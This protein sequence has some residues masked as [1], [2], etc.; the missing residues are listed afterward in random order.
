MGDNFQSLQHFLPE[1]VLIFTILFVIITDLVPSLKVYS[2]NFTLFGAV[3]VGIMMIIMGPGNKLIFE[4]MLMD[5]VFS[6]YFKIIIL[7]STISVILVSKYSNELDDEY[8]VE[9]NVLLLIALLGMF[10]MTS[11]VNLIMIYLSLE[12]VSIPS[13]ILAGILKNDKKSNEASLKYV[14]FGSFASGLMLFGFS[15]L[16]GI[17]GSTNIYD[18]YKSILVL[19]DSSILLISILFILV[20]FGY[21]IS[22]VPFHYWTP[23]VYE[24]SPTTITAFLSVAPKAAGFA[25]FLRTFFFTFTI[26]GSFVSTVP[27]LNINWPLLIAILSA[28]TMTIGNLLALRQVNVKRMLAYSTI[29]HVGFMLMALCTLNIEAISGIMFY[30]LMYSFMNLSAF[31]MIIFTS[32]NLGAV[33]IDDWNGV[34]FKNPVL[35]VFMVL[36]LVSLA[37][38]PPTSGFIGKVYLFRSLFYDKEFFWL[39][40]IGILNSVVSLY[41]Y[42]RIV[43]AMYFKNDDN[44]DKIKAHPVIYWSII[45]LSSQ[46]LLFYLY[47]SPLYEFLIG[48]FS[49]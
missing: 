44:T 36:S 8:R 21:K 27:I 41:Y 46:N 2:F 42:F 19:Q 48:I 18:V 30:L 23:D 9:Y 6:F 49:I 25:L 3:L 45:L 26:D 12:L 35:G 1:L 43:K 17:S 34:G 28:A 40:I 38:L 4:S 14:I 39:A 7:F 47:W 13:Y 24:G 15:Y 31:Y 32:N 5:D 29:S 22:M 10:L 11:S 33:N 16:Y 37:G 20:G